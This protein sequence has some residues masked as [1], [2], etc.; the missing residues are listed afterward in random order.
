MDD[1][2]IKRICESAGY[3]E[4]RQRGDY[5]IG[6]LKECPEEKIEWARREADRLLKKHL[7]DHGN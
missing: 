1:E 4:I 3:L 5:Y 2:T 6:I 7:K